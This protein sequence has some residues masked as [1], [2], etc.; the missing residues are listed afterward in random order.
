MMNFITLAISNFIGFI[1]ERSSALGV[2]AK[3]I[4]LAVLALFLLNLASAYCDNGF[5]RNGQTVIISWK[6]DIKLIAGYMLANIAMLGI[7]SFILCKI[8]FTFCYG[9]PVI[10]PMAIIAIIITKSAVLIAQDMSKFVYT[11]KSRYM[12][13]TA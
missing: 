12:S 13:V 11:F 1:T 10:V 5:Y 9:L 8:A 3:F 6:R 2:T 4:Y 7:T